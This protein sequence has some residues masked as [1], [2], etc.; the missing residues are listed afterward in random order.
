MATVAVGTA[1]WLVIL[2]ILLADRAGLRRSG[3][4]WWVPTAAVGFG[5][6]LLGIAFL[7]R[8]QSRSDRSSARSSESS[9]AS[10]STGS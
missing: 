4:L 7:L 6:G 3:H 5:L 1:A 9:S 10:S 8:R 2:L